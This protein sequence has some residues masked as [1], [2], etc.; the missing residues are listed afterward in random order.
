MTGI[1][2]ASPQGGLHVGFFSPAFPDSGAANG[3]VTYVRY[4]RDALRAEGH[5]VTILHGSGFEDAEGQFHPRTDRLSPIERLRA[6]ADRRM[7]LRAVRAGRYFPV[8]QSFRQAHAFAPLDV[9]EMEES[10]G[11]ARMLLGRGVPVV[12]RLHGPHVFGRDAEESPEQLIH[13]NARLVAEGRLIAQ[14][15]AVTSPSA[16]LLDATLAHY[17]IR[18][19]RA[20]TI[21]NPMPA[22][23]RDECWT[24]DGCDRDQL[25]VVGRFDTR[26]GADIVLQAFQQALR[27]RPTLKLVMVGPDNGITLEGGRKLPF[28][29]YV[30]DH[31]GPEARARLTFLGPRTSAEIDA[32]R[33]RSYL[34][35]VGSRFETYSYSLA[36]AMAFG[37]AAIVANV[38]GAGEI[39]VDGETG[40]VVP[41]GDATAIADAMVT[42]HERPERVAT[43]AAAAWMRCST[44]LDPGRV[45]RETVDLYRRSVP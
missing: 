27:R 42:L 36:E 11:W 18:R 6:A 29:D 23:P 14:A 24:L 5:R 1:G 21:P 16:R 15:S 41:V 40:L 30:R 3:V 17:A 43:M 33:R 26:K 32:L 28:D 34:S 22:L 45:A 37:M 7:P 38:F 2:G 44:L 8:L 12:A 10:F 25:L 19:D 13:S 31:V 35:I 39:M 20:E 9:V 4:M